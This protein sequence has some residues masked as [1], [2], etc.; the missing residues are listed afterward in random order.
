MVPDCLH[1]GLA[2]HRSGRVSL[3]DLMHASWQVFVC[4]IFFFASCHGGARVAKWCF[5]A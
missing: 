4:V 5:E 2:V 1:F 3:G